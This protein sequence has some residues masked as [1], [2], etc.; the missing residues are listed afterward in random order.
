MSISIAGFSFPSSFQLIIK[1][2]AAL[3]MIGLRECLF[4]IEGG[5]FFVVLSN[6]L[7]PEPMDFGELGLASQV[8]ECFWPFTRDRIYVLQRRNLRWLEEEAARLRQELVS[9]Q[10]ALSATLEREA[11][12]ARLIAAMY[13][14]KSW[15]LDS[16]TPRP[17]QNPKRRHKA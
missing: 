11:R 16:P 13:G 14:S 4:R 7:P 2:L 10:V 15:K 5:E 6:A 8:E 12:G 9:T 17:R 1:T 3:N